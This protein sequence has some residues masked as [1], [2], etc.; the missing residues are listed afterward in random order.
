M[1]K[2]LRLIEVAIDQIIESVN[3]AFTRKGDELDFANVSGLE[4]DGSAG[5]DIETKAFGGLAIEL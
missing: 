4:T 5:G 3:A 1:V 2:V